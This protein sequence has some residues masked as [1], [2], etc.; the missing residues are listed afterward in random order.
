VLKEQV[1]V[2]L[3]E[4]YRLKTKRYRR[5]RLTE[6]KSGSDAPILE[7]DNGVSL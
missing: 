1:D 3:H 4:Q 2:L 7:F 5:D 6:L